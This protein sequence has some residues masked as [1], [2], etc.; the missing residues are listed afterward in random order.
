MFAATLVASNSRK[1]SVKK[2]LN[3]V[4]VL[5]DIVNPAALKATE[6]LKVQFVHVS[7]T[8]GLTCVST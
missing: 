5:D 8:F 4:V 7:F 2:L 6:P 3:V 1:P